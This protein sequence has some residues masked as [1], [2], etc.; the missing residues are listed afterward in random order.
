[1][2]IV[3]TIKEQTVFGFIGKINVLLQ[4]N[5]QY[6]G[7]VY[8]KDGLIVHAEYEGQKG[9]NSLFNL[10]LDD[11]ETCK[12]FRFIVEP[13]VVEDAVETF[14]FTLTEFQFQA[15]SLYNKYLAAKSLRP[16]DHL[17]L[18]VNPDFVLQGDDITGIEFNVLCGIVD[19]VTVASLYENSLLFD[20]EITNALIS[21]R[22]KRAIMVAK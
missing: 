3:E 9:K 21:L 13:E 8:L 2:G 19:S 5:N 12:K 14:K 17:S 1:M 6:V 10:V 11:L 22:K 16:P 15:E 18:T 7:V 4:D 20:A